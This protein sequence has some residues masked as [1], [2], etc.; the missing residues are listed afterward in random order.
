[1]VQL[2]Q[3]TGILGTG[4]VHG[5]LEC[6]NN[7]TSIET[8]SMTS[9]TSRERTSASSE[10]NRF[11]SGRSRVLLCVVSTIISLTVVVVVEKQIR[12]WLQSKYP[13]FGQYVQ[14][15]DSRE[16]GYFVPNL[17]IMATGEFASQSIRL[18]TN[19]KG[20]RNA[21]EFSYDVPDK[22]FRVLFMGDS[23]VA[24]FRTDQ[25]QIIGYRL[26]QY[27]KVKSKSNFEQHEVMIACENNPAV[28]WYRYQEHG[29]KYDPHLVILG[30]TI[31]NDITPRDYKHTLWPESNG[32]EDGTARL[33]KNQRS[34]AH[35]M[36]RDL[37]LPAEAYCKKALGNFLLDIELKGRKSLA[38]RLA[39]CGNV[40]PPV[41]GSPGPNRPYHVYAG[42]NL[43]SL[44][45]IYSP[46]LPEVDHWFRE[47]HEII[48]GMK[49]RVA[50]NG[51]DFLLVLF[52]TRCQVDDRDWQAL[53][54]FYCLDAS[55]FDLDYPN[56]RI[57]EFCQQDQISC[58]DLTP[59]FRDVIRE[60][61]DRLY[62]G[63]GDMHFN[64]RG[65]ALAARH[66]GEYICS[67]G[68]HAL[69]DD[70]ES[71][72]AGDMNAKADS[73]RKQYR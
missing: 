54:R 40:I 38:R 21:K 59:R 17:D 14:R 26:E 27:L 13:D 48:V 32:S 66:V 62:M 10:R 47:F 42:G 70:A 61:G 9:A 2:H 73:G 65:Q 50:A 53:T 15:D 60:R 5:W 37:L 22:T 19:S 25:E 1:M 29:W 28:S 3:A 30:I 34:A 6:D 44:G 23:Y 16:G 56:R 69:P 45:L 31:G 58:L 11:S 20:F 4:G 35:Q 8:R 57:L 64:V 51:S 49:K 46:L 33:I 67:M 41:I 24:G 63:R 68:K 18:I 43:T 36:G 39:N 12:R 55:K 7:C 71:D 52:P 72:D